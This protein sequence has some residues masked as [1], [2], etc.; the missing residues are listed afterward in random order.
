MDLERMTRPELIA[1]VTRLRNLVVRAG[2]AAS[3]ATV[4]ALINGELK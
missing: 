3:V 4:G 1:E 2:G